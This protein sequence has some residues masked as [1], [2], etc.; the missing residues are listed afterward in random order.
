MSHPD[1]ELLADLALGAD[2]EAS[3]EVRDHVSGCLVCAA[4]VQDLRRT[5]ALA[6]HTESSPAWSRPPDRVWSRI[7]DAVSAQP[8]TTPGAA[9]T[10]PHPA[11]PA[12]APVTTLES[13]RTPRSPRR[14]L[15]WA[16]GMAAAGL[17]V[18]LLSGRAL[19]RD[20]P[21]PPSATTIA[22]AELDTLDTK[23]PRGEASVVRSNG[24]INLK[25]RTTG[26][27]D[28]GNGFLEVW[29]I[30]KDGKRMVSVGVLGGG[31]AELLPIT[32]ALI[33]QGYVIVDV[34]REGFDDK[35]Q[36]SGDSLVRG[37]LRT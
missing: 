8:A 32:Q 28:A 36:H 3:S 21:P 35:P 31:E 1:D 24:A 25:I 26:S 22:Q 23:Q 29:L 33:D 34:S 20:T 15:P 12:P 10:P 13:R 4:T 30:N 18:G 14:V 2:L 6:A 11:E 5:L 7:E 17:A 37:T 16:A 27:L 19:W 9:S